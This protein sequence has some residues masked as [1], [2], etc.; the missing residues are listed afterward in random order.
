MAMYCV[1]VELGL[2]IHDA[3]EFV[4]KARPESNV[5]E[6][7]KNQLWKIDFKFI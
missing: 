6:H 4:E 7:F 3:I 2:T 5:S 1:A